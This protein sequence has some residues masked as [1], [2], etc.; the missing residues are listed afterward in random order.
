MCTYI[1]EMYTFKPLNTW[2][3]APVLP[4]WWGRGHIQLMVEISKSFLEMCDIDVLFEGV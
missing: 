2:G 4:V 3:L 1:Y